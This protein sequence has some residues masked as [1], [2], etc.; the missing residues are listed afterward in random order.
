[1][2]M[3]SWYAISRCRRSHYPASNFSLSLCHP[4]IYPKEVFVELDEAREDLSSSP[5]MGTS[6]SFGPVFFPSSSSPSSRVTSPLV[7]SLAHEPLSSPSRSASGP[8]GSTKS[9]HQP[10]GSSFVL[11][12][13]TKLAQQSQG[14]AY[15][16]RN[17]TIASRDI[18]ASSATTLSG[19]KTPIVSSKVPSSP[20][21][22]FS[23]F[24][25][26]KV[27]LMFFACGVSNPTG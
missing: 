4:L 18:R 6:Y 2:L 25:G 12:A 27:P 9:L 26:R 24:F 13:E 21:G 15:R 14:Q 23:S 17:S 11:G 19:S 5:S 16:A 7:S 1:M 8:R 10:Q 20:S 3:V 22:L